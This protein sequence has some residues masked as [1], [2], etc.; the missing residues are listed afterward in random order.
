MRNPGR[1]IFCTLTVF[2]LSL[3]AQAQAPIALTGTL[4]M[5]ETVIENGTVLIQD[6]RIIASG[7]H[8]TLPAGDQD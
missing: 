3:A 2:F 4:V 6:G 1:Q 5:P 7:A 8:V